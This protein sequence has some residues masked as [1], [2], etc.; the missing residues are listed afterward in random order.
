MPAFPLV[1]CGP[2]FFQDVSAAEIV[3]EVCRDAEAP[4][5]FTALNAHGL[6]LAL[7]SPAYSALLNQ[8]HLCSC[9]GFGIHLF[10]RLFGFGQ[11]RHRNTPTDYL[12]ELLRRLASEGKRVFLVGDT[13]E[14]VSSFARKTEERY[15]GLVAGF[16]SG[17]F[18]RGSREEE[19]L[20]AVINQARPHAILVGMGNPRQE[21]WAAEN[22]PRLSCA[23]LCMIGAS[24]A[25][26]L[27]QRRRGP[28]WATD[29]G[30]EGALRLLFEP[31]RMWRRYLVEIPATAW[32]LARTRHS[33]P[34]QPR[35]GDA[36]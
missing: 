22:A 10:C 13:P 16:H 15:P 20:I 12:P 3:E 34:T 28:R 11:P 17:F 18:D 31:A 29:R 36:A 6:D 30:L 5:L 7:K 2:V 27:G 33:F 14:I 23:A 25:F 9:D 21:Y 35:L 19:L 26:L 32:L 4:R 24:M 1:Q 8:S